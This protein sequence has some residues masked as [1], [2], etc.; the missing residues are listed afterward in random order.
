MAE[1]CQ[2]IADLPD[3]EE[4]EDEDE[5]PPPEVV[6]LCLI[7]PE[8]VARTTASR[9]GARRTTSTASAS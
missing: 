9:L 3:Q 5:D 7:N 8:P 4:E 2:S 6:D 1:D